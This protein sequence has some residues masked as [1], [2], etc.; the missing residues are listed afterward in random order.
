LKSSQ[1][2]TEVAKP[3]SQM[4]IFSGIK[5]ELSISTLIAS[6]EALPHS[7]LKKHL[8]MPAVF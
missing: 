7:I 8:S 5:V 3:L 2:P 4:P 6:L 1:D